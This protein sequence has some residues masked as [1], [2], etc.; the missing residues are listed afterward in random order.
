MI[1]LKNITEAQTIM[2][3]RNGESVSGQMSLVL[4]NT[5]DHQSHT[6]SVADGGASGL[7]AEVA[8]TLPEGL[9]VG[10]YHYQ[11]MSGN[12][13]VSTG[14]VFIGDLRSPSQYEETITYKQYE[15]E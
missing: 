14:L 5:T 10:E 15:S 4:T 8:V 1:Y 9:A 12:E 13:A 3:P 2:I 11:L 7:Y 6:L